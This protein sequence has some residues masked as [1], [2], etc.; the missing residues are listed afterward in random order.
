[1]KILKL[2]GELKSVFE[3]NDVLFYVN[4]NKIDG[5]LSLTENNIKDGE[6]ITISKL[7]NKKRHKESNLK[8]IYF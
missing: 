5:K 6:T 8:M 4:G 2:N 1:M 7:R 3:T